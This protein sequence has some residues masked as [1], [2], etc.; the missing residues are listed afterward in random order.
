[1]VNQVHL[2]QLCCLESLS[3]FCL[4][5]FTRLIFS[6][7]RTGFD[8]QQSRGNVECRQGESASNI[9]DSTNIKPQWRDQ[10]PKTSLGTVGYIGDTYPLCNTGDKAS[11]LNKGSTFLLTGDHSEESNKFDTAQTNIDKGR[12]TPR[13][14]T[15]NLYTQLC[16]PRTAG[17]KCSWPTEVQ[18]QTTLAC[19]G[20]ECHLDRIRTVKMI[21]GT[22]V[23]WYSYFSPPCVTLTFFNGV[24]TSSRHTDSR[25]SCADPTLAVASPMCC[26]AADSTDML[27]DA[28]AGTWYFAAEMTTLATAKQTCMVNSDECTTRMMN[29]S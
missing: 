8:T 11:F 17:G 3:H 4:F 21:D 28:P 5:F 20:D 2:L 15:S 26:K 24:R 27:P 16:G 25:W 12:F 7:V 6:F 9:F 1:M 13:S 18:L 29:A 23:K 14:T 19:D 22:D 10:Y